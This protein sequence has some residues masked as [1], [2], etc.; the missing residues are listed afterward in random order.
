MICNQ[1]TST[2]AP[3]AG[4]EISTKIWVKTIGKNCEI[5]EIM[6]NVGFIFF[7]PILKMQWQLHVWLS[8]EIKEFFF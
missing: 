6:G 4:G 7:K 8:I 5:S 2:G 3:E 1:A